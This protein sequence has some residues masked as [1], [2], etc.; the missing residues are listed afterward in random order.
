MSSYSRPPKCASQLLATNYHLA[1]V[2]PGQK[3]GRKLG[4]KLGPKSR[5]KLG[6]KLLTEIA[7]QNR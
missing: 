3:L 4:L 6:P 2:C 7:D 5:L 1:L